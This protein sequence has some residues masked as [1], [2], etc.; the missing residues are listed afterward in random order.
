MEQ[1]FTN[2]PVIIREIYRD[3][4]KWVKQAAAWRVFAGGLCIHACT[5]GFILLLFISLYSILYTIG[6]YVN[7]RSVRKAVLLY[8][9]SSRFCFQLMDPISE[10][11]S[12]PK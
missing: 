12:L 11:S 2:A 10:N 9:L 3:G 1:I 8:Q 5:I 4:F 7:S 6:A